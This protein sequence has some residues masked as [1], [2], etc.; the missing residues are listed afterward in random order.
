MKSVKR[1]RE[2][3]CVKINNRR[4]KGGIVWEGGVERSVRFLMICR[5]RV[6]A[7]VLFFLEIVLLG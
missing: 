6:G 1:E 2:E 5:E 4:L 3:V 7:C